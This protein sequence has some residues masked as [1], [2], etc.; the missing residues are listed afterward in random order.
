MRNS[1]LACVRH[2]DHPGLVDFL[3]ALPA[4]R[5]LLPGASITAGTLPFGR[6]LAYRT[7]HGD[8]THTQFE[9]PEGPVL[10][11]TTAGGKWG[12][13]LSKPETLV[14]TRLAEA[15][16]G[17]YAGVLHRRS[18]MEEPLRACAA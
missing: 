14:F 4:L 17:R 13:T 5:K 12:L 16:W 18:L 3:D 10:G 2:L 15:P 8:R 11:Y 9:T 6:G 1:F 7:T